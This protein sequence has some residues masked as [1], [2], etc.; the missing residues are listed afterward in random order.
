[1]KW[2]PGLPTSGTSF[3]QLLLCTDLDATPDQIFVWIVLRRQLEVT[4]E[5]AR[6]HLDVETQPQWSDPAISRTTSA[7][8]GLLSQV[9]LYAHQ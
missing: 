9:T 8:P 2:V 5:A 6:R 3:I 1:M 4:F 7:L